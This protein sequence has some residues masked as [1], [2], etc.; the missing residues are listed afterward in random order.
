MHAVVTVAGLGAREQRAPEA[1][2]ELSVHEQTGWAIWMPRPHDTLHALGVPV[3][4]EQQAG[5]VHEVMF[6]SGWSCQQ[7]LPDS[8]MVLSAQEHL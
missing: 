7:R 8:S 2:T 6:A 3:F 1:S 4:Q 5:C